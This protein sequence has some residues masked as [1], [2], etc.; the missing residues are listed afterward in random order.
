VVLLYSIAVCTTDQL[1]E[2]VSRSAETVKSFAQPIPL[3]RSS[4]NGLEHLLHRLLNP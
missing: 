3:D 2:V 1:T 4:R